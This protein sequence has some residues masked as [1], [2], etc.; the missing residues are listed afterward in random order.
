MENTTISI[1][2]AVYEAT[3]VAMSSTSVIMPLS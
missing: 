2:N 1:D 3:N